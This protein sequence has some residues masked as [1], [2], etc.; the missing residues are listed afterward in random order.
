MKVSSGVELEQ[1]P[2]C[3]V[4]VFPW[5]WLAWSW[6]TEPL[7]CPSTQIAIMDDR[8]ADQEGPGD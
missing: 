6:A 1:L 8:C 7:K 2:G 3:R 4:E 5:E